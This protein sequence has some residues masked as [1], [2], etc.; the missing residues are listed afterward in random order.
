MSEKKWLTETKSFLIH[1]FIEPM[2][3]GPHL[4]EAN[5]KNKRF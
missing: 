5:T 3:D 2:K 4:H 1:F